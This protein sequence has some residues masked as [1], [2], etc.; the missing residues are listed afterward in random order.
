MMIISVGKRIKH[1]KTQIVGRI[2]RDLCHVTLIIICKE[3]F[4]HDSMGKKSSNTW[5]KFGSML[6]KSPPR[7]ERYIVTKMIL[8]RETRR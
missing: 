5:G 2:L 6:G 3:T 1:T 7:K 8:Y 4:K